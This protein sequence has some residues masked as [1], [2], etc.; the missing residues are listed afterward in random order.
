MVCWLLSGTGCSL[1]CWLIKT[2]P[3]RTNDPS[4]RRHLFSPSLVALT[5]ATWLILA[6]AAVYKPASNFNHSVT[7]HC[8]DGS[9]SVN[10]LSNPVNTT[11]TEALVT[12]TSF[13]TKK[14]HL[15]KTKKITFKGQ[16]CEKQMRRLWHLAC[17][18]SFLSNYYCLCLF[19]IS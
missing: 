6:S 9:A 3:Q 17:G 12:I 10:F 7:S 8:L 14:T 13:Y 15:E 5:V 18:I 11:T 16:I 19:L 4:A 1:F 2:V